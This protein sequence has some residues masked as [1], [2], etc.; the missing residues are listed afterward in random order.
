MTMLS[1]G[2]VMV[3]SYKFF[4]LLY[5]GV[6]GWCGEIIIL[7]SDYCRQGNNAGYLSYFSEFK[8]SSN[9]SIRS[10]FVVGIA[11]V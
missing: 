10:G 1:C 7:G 8:P 3:L 4:I 6:P 9:S 5:V 11:Q 2:K